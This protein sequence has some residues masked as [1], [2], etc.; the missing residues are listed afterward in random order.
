MPGLI[1]WPELILILVIVVFIFGAG[2]ITEL[3]KAVGTSVKEYKKAT[4]DNPTAQPSKDNVIR[5][6]AEKMGISTEGKSTSQL[7]EEMDKK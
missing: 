5:E 1:G 7:M 6:A 3:A 2:R 4:S